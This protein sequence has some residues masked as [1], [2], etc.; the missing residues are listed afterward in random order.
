M[1]RFQFI[2]DP[3]PGLAGLDAADFLAR[4][5]GP[6]C[7]FFTGS[8]STRTRVLVTLLHG[9]EPSGVMA[10]RRFLLA[11]RQPAV[12]LLCIVASVHAAIKEPLFTHRMLPGVRDLNRCFRAPFDDE[13]GSLAKEILDLL[14]SHGPESVVDMHNTSG[15]GPS[16]GVCTHIDR[17]HDA[18]ASLFT[19]R[20]IISRIKLG[21]LME[22]SDTRC[23]TVTVEVGGR[24][25]AEAHELAFD[26]LQRYATSEQV[27]AAEGGDDWGL[28]LLDD[29]VRL[30]LQEGVSLTYATSPQAGYDITLMPD[31]EHHNFGL[32]HRDTPLGWVQAAPEKL[33][34]ASGASAGRP[35][36]A[37]VRATES[38]L[39]PAQTLKLFMITTNATI[40]Q[41]DCLFYAV[42][43]D[44]APLAARSA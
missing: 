31:I 12:N 32:V 14:R 44:G 34:R 5:G 30:E 29:P 21:A 15:S 37:L 43:D 9:N 28:E 24:Q 19:R 40:A 3:E 10:L 35:V 2:R 11:K 4:L 39:F 36:S 33:F 7:L 38:T 26:G 6:S 25:D 18:L 20:L 8:D 41:T 23:P 1:K 13:Q 27:F 22:I 42:V 17:Q 16:F